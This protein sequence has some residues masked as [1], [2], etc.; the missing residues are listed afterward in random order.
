MNNL[1][2]T[3]LLLV[4][5]DLASLRVWIVFI[6]FLSW[7][8]D[9]TVDFGEALSWGYYLLSM[10]LIEYLTIDQGNMLLV[11]CIGKVIASIMNTSKSN[12]I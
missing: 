4:Q 5:L 7:D 10:M 11:V 9:F 3:N 2:F 12:L 8:V 6:Q 1:K